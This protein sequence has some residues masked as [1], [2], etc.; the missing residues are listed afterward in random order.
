[1]RNS[2][3]KVVIFGAGLV[4]EAV[5]RHI[6]EQGHDLCFIESNI[7]TVRKVRE[8]MDVQI[9][10]GAGED[11][12]VLREARIQ[13]A[14]LILALTNQ[15]KSNIIL[16]LISRS[17]NPNARIV[18]RVKDDAFLNNHQLWQFRDLNDTMI[19]SPERA[20]IEKAIHILDVQHAFDL[21]DFPDNGVRVAGFRLGPN[22]V[23][24]NRPLREAIP[25]L[26]SEL[27]LVVGAQR[28]EEV[29]I[30][31][32][33]TVLQ[34]GDRIC[35]TLPP[36]ISLPVILPM[37]GKSYIQQQKFV[38][39]GGGP[40]AVNIARQLERRG[41][42]VVMIES[43]YD[44]CQ[45]LA[46]MLSKT[47]IL[48]GDPTDANLLGRA[49]TPQTVFLAM[50]DQQEVNFFIALLARKR[51]AMQVV[52]MMDN[53]AYFSLAPEL[54]VDAI[55]S[56]RAAAVGS[57]LRFARAGRVLDAD[58]LLGGRLNLF[59][60]EVEEGSRLDGS[61]LKELN[62][63]K[64]M[65]VAASI[66]GSRVAVPHGNL[67]LNKGDRALLVLQQGKA[68]LLDKWIAQA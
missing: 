54:G 66:R 18:L 30:P 35:M 17:L 55:L 52:S 60:A 38:I 45:T 4:G 22:N 8:Q 44:H 7:N 53:E 43:D 68:S 32:G 65:I 21:V 36:G 41:R 58:I 29:F 6:A 42:Q 51:G 33:D 37:L 26:P 34:S 10:H 2:P 23:L 46:E 1:M 13:E 62:L 27:L 64:G 14:D 15:D 47:V 61:L 50:T 48:H 59:L 3:M 19:I 63:P 5:G 16:T 56:P 25:T 57:I 28:G 9:V 31:T 49:I 67:R 24:A 20:V 39:V 40:I 11:Q 12:D